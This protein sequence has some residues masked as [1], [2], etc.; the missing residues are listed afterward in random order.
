MPDYFF[1]GSRV[2][3]T[4]RADSD[5]DMVLRSSELPF[6]IR[7]LADSQAGSGG[8][9]KFGRLNVIVLSDEEFLRW[10]SVTG[11]LCL[12]RPVTH[13]EAI[14]AF[15]EAGAVEHQDRSFFPDTPTAIQ[16]PTDE[17][18]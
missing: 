6:S 11:S 13:E 10:A 9:L 14:R 12:R 17:W 18:I 16:E 15:R 7:G 4:P 3:G 2:Y 8:S 1:T 5:L